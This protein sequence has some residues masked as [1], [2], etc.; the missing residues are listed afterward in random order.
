MAGD[1]LKF[2]KGLP[3]KPE[4][5]SMS[6]QLGIDRD[7]VA[8]KL[9]RLW[10]WCDDNVAEANVDENGHATVTL[11]AQQVRNIDSIVGVSGFADAMSAAGW[12][13]VRQGSLTFPNF[14]RHNGEP[15]KQRALAAIRKRRS[16]ANQYPEKMSRKNRDQR[17]E[18]KNREESCASAH[19][20]DQTFE[21]FWEVFPS[22]R[23]KSKAV[24]RKAWS[25]AVQKAAAAEIILAAVE[26][27]TSKEG[28]GQFCKMPS[29][30]LNGECWNDD[31]KAWNR[32]QGMF[33]ERAAPAI[34]DAFAKAKA[35][36][37]AASGR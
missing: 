26:Y 14:N 35:D 3:E 5:F 33:D 7:Y 8:G 30:W 1:W 28:Q 13:H 9:M 22:V 15:A 20:S 16:R 37:E 24:A 18:E 19:D 11:G 12:L 23:K 21:R 2:C 6:E 36:R 25:G 32:K 17:R 31:R 4:V 29:T 27:A 34:D 10:G